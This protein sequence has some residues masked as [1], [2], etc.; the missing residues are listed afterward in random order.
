M[1][2]DVHSEVAPTDLRDFLRTNGWVAVE[3]ALRERLYVFR[4]SA[5]ARRQLIFP[6]DTS[7]PDYADSVA[8]VFDKLSELTGQPPAGLRTRVRFVRDDVLNLRIYSARSDDSVLPM[9]FA[10]DL[11]QNTA[12]LL[13]AAACTVV[14]PRARHPKLSLNDAVGLVDRSRFGQTREGSFMLQVACPIHA[15]EAEGALPPEDSTAPFVRR[16]TTAVHR[17]L[18]ALTVAIEADRL[19]AFVDELKRSDAPLLSSNL[20]EAVSGMYDETMGNSLDV[21]FDWS[22][23]HPVDE[24]LRRPVRIQR[25]YFP[26]IEEVHQELRAVAQAEDGPLPFVGTVER[27]DGHLNR[28]GR[29]SGEV[30]LA[31]LLPDEDEAV[32]VK[33]ELTADDYQKAAQAHMT[34]NA[35]VRVVG[36]LKPGRQ[37]R[38]LTEVSSFDVIGPQSTSRG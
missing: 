18:S 11:V 4:S 24:S 12:K 32:R 2:A 23:M 1:S 28:N 5:H 38:R 15:I 25:D 22:S 29:R 14:R 37:P 3:E 19:D 36:R 27:L 30:L 31:L 13:K 9:S 17:S 6:M 21:G 10:A 8:I 7:A 33:I 34:N 26:R 35:Y 16:V 20:C